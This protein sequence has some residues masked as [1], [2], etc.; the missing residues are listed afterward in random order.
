MISNLDVSEPTFF[1]SSKLN[2][3]P[4]PIVKKNIKIKIEQ[5]EEGEGGL[6]SL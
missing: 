2:A 1:T 4:E 5:Q 3:L 6:T